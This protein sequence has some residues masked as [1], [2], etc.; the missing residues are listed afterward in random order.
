MFLS[1]AV[2]G[3]EYGGYVTR[4]ERPLGQLSDYL[5]DQLGVTNEAIR[6]GEAAAERLLLDVDKAL[7]ALDVDL[8]GRLGTGAPARRRLACLDLAWAER[9]VAIAFGGTA[10]YRARRARTTLWR[11]GTTLANV[12]A[13][14]PVLAWSDIAIHHPMHDPRS[15]LAPGSGRDQEIFMYRVQGAIERMSRSILD[16]WQSADTSVAELDELTVD[17]SLIVAAMAHLIRV[18]DIGEFYKLDP[19]LGPNNEVRGHGTGSFSAWTFL[20]SWLVTGDSEFDSRL[21]DPANRMAFDPDAR[22]WIDELAHGRL[23]PLPERARVVTSAPV[24]S[25]LLNVQK[26]CRDFHKAHRGGIRR[27]AP[28]SMPFPAPANPTITN[29]DSINR[30]ATDGSQ[31][32]PEVRQ[33]FRDMTGK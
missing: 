25:A 21:T 20:V 26:R 32:R 13:R 9:A 24:A 12:E 14:H 15:F 2:P 6:T 30:A 18:R 27:H 28:T 29:E 16:T 17:L 11:W 33:V 10:D 19:F 8:L 3:T 4:Q 31:P 5:C 22:A 23:V 7:D 1:R